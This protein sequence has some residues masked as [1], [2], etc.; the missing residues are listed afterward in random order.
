MYTIYNSCINVFIQITN[1]V[2]V[3]CI[4]YDYQWNILLLTLIP[5]LT[6]STK[7]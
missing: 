5:R 7:F 6:I 1:V 2:F 3:Q 4:S